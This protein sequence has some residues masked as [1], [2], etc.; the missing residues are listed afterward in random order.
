[1]GVIIVKVI[2]YTGKNLLVNFTFFIIIFVV[3]WDTLG[4][5]I[6]Y[7][8]NSTFQVPYDECIPNA[9]VKIVNFLIKK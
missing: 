6:F 2:G 1:M 4:M 9:T 7:F 3:V 5:C 8:L